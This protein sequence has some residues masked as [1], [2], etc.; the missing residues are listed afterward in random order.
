MKNNVDLIG[1][2]LKKQAYLD[3][4]CLQINLKEIFVIYTLCITHD[5]NGFVLFSGF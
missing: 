3:P 4:H 2:L 1:Q 5:L